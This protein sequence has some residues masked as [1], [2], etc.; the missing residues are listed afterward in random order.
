VDSPDEQSRSWEAITKSVELELLR[1]FRRTHPPELIEATARESVREI[2]SEEVRIR[3]FVPVLASSLAR[4]RL[5][6]RE[7]R[8]S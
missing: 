5:R 1:E 2:A 7:R 3:S 6:Q 8:A 4:R